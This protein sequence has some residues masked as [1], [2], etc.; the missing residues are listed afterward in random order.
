MNLKKKQKKN[1]QYAFQLLKRDTCNISGTTKSIKLRRTGNF[2]CDIEIEHK[3]SYATVLSNA[4]ICTIS[5]M[6]KGIKLK[7]P[8]N[9]EGDVEL[10]TLKDA[11]NMQ[12]IKMVCAIPWGW[13]RVLM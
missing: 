12:V 6:A 9:V 5:G 2:D 7:L 1:T 4:G 10:R 8:G 11:M 13:L 3:T